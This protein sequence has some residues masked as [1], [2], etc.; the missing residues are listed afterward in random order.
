MNKRFILILWILVVACQSRPTH[1]P[2]AE[3]ALYDTSS[4]FYTDF[5]AYPAL[6]NHLPIGIFDSGTGGLTVLEAIL[7]SRL[8]E[9]EDFIYLADQ[10]NM[11]YGNYPSEG[12]TDFLRELI[13]K[14]ALFL[15][16]HQVKILV[17]AC[18][19]ATAYGLEDIKK[20][21][22]ESGSGIKAIG[23]IHAGV[24]ATLDRIGPKEDLAVGV[25]ATTGTIASGG[26]ENTFR[27][28]AKERGYT[29]NLQIISHGAVG[30]AE[31]VDSEK[32]YVDPRA[33]VPRDDYRGPST[34]H[35]AYRIDT[36]LLAAYGFDFSA[37]HMLY[38]GNKDRPRDLQ[39]N[40]AEN[41]ARYHL[42][43]LVEKLRNS[44][45]PQPL[46]YLVL[47]CTHFP[48]ESHT[49]SLMLSELREYNEGGQYPYR[50][51]I[52]E[53]VIL[54]DPAFETA[55]ELYTT[56]VKDS[57]LTLKMGNTQAAFYISVPIEDPGLN[58]ILDSAGR[59][60]YDYKYGR[61]PGVFTKDVNIVPFSTENIDSLTRDRL[62]SL[63]YTW[64]LLPFGSK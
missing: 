62:R 20:F 44:K 32:D 13:V 63:R 28:F 17:V 19:T 18:N 35:P 37:N 5:S 54:I 21:L 48:Y 26:Y 64:P 9:G 43:S 59:F 12:K 2:V 55:R 8:L 50:D 34:D 52:D 23:V 45:N 38:N 25:L 49:L 29:G 1:I 33:L 61:N 56:L 3:A 36:N 39:L 47:G 15:L 53:E 6:R 22:D 24:N 11:P 7:S 40:S 14:D 10:A 41:Y 51:L 42:L 30:F 57:L 4:V 58:W 31:A 16:G 60:S 27:S 46:R